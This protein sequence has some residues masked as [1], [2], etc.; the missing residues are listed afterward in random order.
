M[1]RTPSI[2]AL[3][4]ALVACGTLGVL[5]TMELRAATPDQSPRDAIKAA[6]QERAEARQ[7][8][9]SAQD[10]S[11]EAPYD[12][13]MVRD[14]VVWRAEAGAPPT[15]DVTI[16][17]ATPGADLAVSAR[18]CAEAIGRAAGTRVQCYAFATTEAYA[19]KNITADLELAE[20]TAIVN[21]CW[22]V[23][24]SNERAG[25]AI[26]VSDMRL[27]PQ[28]WNAHGCPDSWR[29]TGAAEVAA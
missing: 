12:P 8:R 6:S 16:V 1:R 9:F 20:P 22:A 17:N 11:F 5:I 25:G 26:T 24:A 19:F 28:T 7:D 23:L 18:E 10:A 14:R 3:L 13:K 15:T 4:F 2:L 21:L 29:G 27:A